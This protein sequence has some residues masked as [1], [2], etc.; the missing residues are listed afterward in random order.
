ME[1]KVLP[2]PALPHMSVG[3]PRGKPPP[4][5]SSSPWIPVGALGNSRLFLL[6]SDLFLISS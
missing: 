3:R 4:V 1:S 2:H 5:I 6:F